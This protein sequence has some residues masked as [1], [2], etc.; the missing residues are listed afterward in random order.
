MFYYQGGA[1][2]RN[3]MLEEIDIPATVTEIDWEAF[4]YCRNLKKVV[5]HT[6]NLEIVLP[7]FKGHCNSSTMIDSTLPHN[8]RVQII[9]R[10]LLIIQSLLTMLI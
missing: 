10:R 6:N 3:Q 9:I 8:L 7:L 2:G 1:F 5:L 4:E